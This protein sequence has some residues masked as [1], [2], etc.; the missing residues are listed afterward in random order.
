MKHLNTKTQFGFSILP[1]ALYIFLILFSACDGGSGTS[2]KASSGTSDEASSDTG[3]I[4]FSLVWEEAA[5]NSGVR[6]AQAQAAQS[7]SGDVCVDYGIDTI[8]ATVYNSSDTEVGS[9]VWPCSAHQGTISGVRTGSGMRIV[10]EGIVSDIVLWRGETTGITVTAGQTTNAGIIIM[11]YIGADAEPPTA[12]S[13]SPPDGA[14]DIAVNSV[15]TATF[16]EAVDPASVNAFS[17]TLMAGKTTVSGSVTYNSSNRTAT[18][19]PYSNLSLATTYTVTITTDV[20]DLANNQMTDNYTWSFTTGSDT[21]WQKRDMGFTLVEQKDVVVGDGRNDGVMRVYSAVD[22]KFYEY[23]YSADHWENSGSFGDISGSIN[24]FAIGTVRNDGAY[25]I[26]A[27]TSFDLHEYYYETDSWLGDDTGG[28][29][30]FPKELVLGNARNDGNVRIYMIDWYGIS[31]VSY[32]Y[33]DWAVMS[34]HDVD[35]YGHGGLVVTDGR[36]D[37]V[38]RLYAAIDDHVYEYSWTGSTWEVEDC[39]VIDV[40]DFADMCAGNGRNDDKNRIYLGATY[41]DGLYELSYNGENWEYIV[42]SESASIEYITI[43][44]GRNDG[45]NRIYTGGSAGIGEY[46][47]S[48]IW[49]KTALIDSGFGVNGIAVGNGR[50]DGVNRVYVTGDD[51]HIYEYSFE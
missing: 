26:C 8:S 40:Y 34:I 13:P 42:I 50:N 33:G 37:G 39:G 25:T 17:F 14:T 11:D 20:Q 1:F 18:F 16:S 5:S 47:Y 38:L 28:D 46:T 30:T 15:V 4:A 49:T 51:S 36:N 10:V 9:R 29:W 22:D 35:L 44:D 45:I 32:N 23:T 48:G 43:A 7:P 19:S 12:G 21:G 3:S 31:E 24:K 2:D 41:D 27:T 6:L